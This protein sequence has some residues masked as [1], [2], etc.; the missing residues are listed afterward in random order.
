MYIALLILSVLINIHFIYSLR[1]QSQNYFS[2]KKH[3]ESKDD[4][5][6]ERFKNE[7]NHFKQIRSLEIA[8]EQNL[9]QKNQEIDSTVE[10]LNS[11]HQG[12]IAVLSERIDSLDAF[13]RQ[14]IESLTAQHEADLQNKVKLATKEAIKKSRSVLRGQATEHLAPFIVTGM[15]PK[16]CRFMGNPIDYICFDGLSDILDGI[17]NEIK[18]V[19]FIDI[20]TGSSSLSKTQRRIRDAIQAS[21]I[22]FTII[23]PEEHI[24]SKQDDEKKTELG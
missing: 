8:L 12:T 7:Q 2:L 21:R 10:I 22:S 3:L 16:D 6:H 1:K 15:N 20:K 4:L 19:K 14:Q 11:R 13:H 17:S 18:E 23:N 24:G 5:L 9:A